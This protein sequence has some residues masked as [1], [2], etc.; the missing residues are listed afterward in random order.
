MVYIMPEAVQ[1]EVDV[2]FLSEVM[3]LCRTPL[4]YKEKPY[5]HDYPLYLYNAR[6]SSD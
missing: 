3:N 2:R 4:F 1:I 6:N 5:D